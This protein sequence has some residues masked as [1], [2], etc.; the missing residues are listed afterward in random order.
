MLLSLGM[1]PLTTRLIS[2]QDFGIA[3][4]FLVYSSVLIRIVL[5]G[6]DQAYVRMYVEKSNF[7][8]LRKLL[9]DSLSIPVTMFVLVSTILYLFKEEFGHFITNSADVNASFLMMLIVFFGALDVFSINNVRMSKNATLFSLISISRVLVNFFVLIGYVYLNG[10]S[11]YAILNGILFSHIFCVC[12]GISFQHR[13]WRPRRIS[14]FKNLMDLLKFGLPY[15]PTFLLLLALEGIDKVFIEKF[16]GAESL[17]VYNIA[18]KIVAV[19]NLVKVGFT[20]FWIPISLEQYERNPNDTVFFVRMSVLI[21]FI[22]FV[23][24]YLIVA[25]APYV[26]PLL[27]ASY[28]SALYFAPLLLLVPLMGLFSEL[29]TRGI[30][31]KKRTVYNVYA[32][33]VAFCT[34]ALMCYLVIPVFGAK[35]AALAMALSYIV[36]FVLKFYFSWRLMKIDYPFRSIITCT[37]IFVFYATWVAF[38][39]PNNWNITVVGMTLIALSFGMYIFDAVCKEG[40]CYYYAYILRAFKS[41]RS[42]N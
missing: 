31:F 17:G 20:D 37:L 27:G 13:L 1:I 22:A 7:E 29:M 9:W 5:L 36:L 42:L 35:G 6:S 4:L 8:E 28:R 33:I 38:F 24:A 25:I 40:M 32:S 23:G 10:P 16:A 3:S 14:N 15:A 12:I 19:F 41:F 2:P 21:S 18:F 30:G 39:E 34:S 26:M 11:Y